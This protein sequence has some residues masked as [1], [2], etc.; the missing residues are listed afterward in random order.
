M[1]S[2][3]ANSTEI[4]KCIE[5]YFLL[6]HDNE[7]GVSNNEF[8]HFMYELIGWAKEC[9]KPDSACHLLSDFIAPWN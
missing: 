4:R 2:Q 6:R 8:V 7:N 9:S 3:V 1:D 5:H